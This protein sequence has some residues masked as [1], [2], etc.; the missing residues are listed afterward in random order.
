MSKNIYGLGSFHI[1]TDN[2]AHLQTLLDLS[3]AEYEGCVRACETLDTYRDLA[4]LFDIVIWNYEDY[5]A[6]FNKCLEA[7]I[8]KKFESFS[9][10]RPDLNLNR[11]MMNL[12]SSIRSYLDY[13]ELNINRQHGKESSIWRNFK[14]RCSGSYDGSF[15]YRFLYRFRNFAQHCGLPLTRVNFNASEDK[16]YSLD[17][18]VSRDDLLNQGF[19]WGAIAQS[20]LA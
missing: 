20:D 13:T 2:T 15:S 6:L 9:I 16:G 17:V 5:S 12:L 3:E 7:Y 8:T 18:G 11:C 19:D 1:L 10:R 14:N 4:Q